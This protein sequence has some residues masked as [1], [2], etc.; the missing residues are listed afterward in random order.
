MFQPNKPN[1]WGQVIKLNT[2]RPRHGLHFADVICKCIILNGYVWFPI[3]ISLKYVPKGLINNI[4]ALV[5]NN[6]NNNNFIA[7]HMI[8]EDNRSYDSPFQASMENDTC[9]N[10]IQVFYVYF[11]LFEAY[12]KGSR[13]WEAYE[14]HIYSTFSVYHKRVQEGLGAGL[15]KKK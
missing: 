10:D 6:N 5:N 8:H 11:I 9:E 15:A 12:G 2:L 4:P 3:K 7:T 14:L 1:I 13:S